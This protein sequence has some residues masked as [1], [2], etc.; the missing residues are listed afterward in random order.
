MST[1]SE[2][3]PVSSHQRG[4]KLIETPAQNKD[5]KGSFISAEEIDK[6]MDPKKMVGNPRHDLGMLDL[7]SR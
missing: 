1:H 7:D 6:V 2:S 5:T 3:Y 4:I